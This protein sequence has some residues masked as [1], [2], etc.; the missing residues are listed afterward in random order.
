LW[1]ARDRPVADASVVF[2]P[3]RPATSSVESKTP[4]AV[5]RAGSSN[6]GVVVGI[7]LVER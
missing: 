7:T 1:K 6:R 5:S 4:D 3:I 2:L